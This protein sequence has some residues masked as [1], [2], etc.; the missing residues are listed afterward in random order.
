MVWWTSTSLFWF[1]LPCIIYLLLFPSVWSLEGPVPELLVDPLFL[2]QSKLSNLV[3]F[4]PH[5][6]LSKLHVTAAVDKPAV[7]SKM[8][9]I[10]HIQECV[11]K[12]KGAK[13]A[14]LYL[15]NFMFREWIIHMNIAEIKCLLI[16]HNLL[17]FIIWRK[18]ITDLSSFLYLYF[19]I[20]I[21]TSS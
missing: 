5:K 2:V 14:F 12:H 19:Y 1:A 15:R 17:Q 9:I 7:T 6:P 13:L 8:H 3:C 16:K 18:F 4:Q 21:F 20:C 11:Y 10:K